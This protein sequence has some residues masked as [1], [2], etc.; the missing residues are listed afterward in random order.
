MPLFLFC[1]MALLS[2]FS[3]IILYNC[4]NWIW[5]I[6]RRL[7]EF[8]KNL[9]KK[10]LIQSVIYNAQ[11]CALKANRSISLFLSSDMDQDFLLATV[12][13][14][15]SAA[16]C[17]KWNLLEDCASLMIANEQ[18]KTLGHLYMSKVHK[19]NQNYREELQELLLAKDI[20]AKE[21]V[22]ILKDRLFLAFIRN[23]PNIDGAELILS[24]QQMSVLHSET[25][26]TFPE[27]YIDAYQLDPNNV[28]AACFLASKWNESIAVKKLIALLETVPDIKVLDKIMQINTKLNRTEIYERIKNAIVSNAMSPSDSYIL[29]RV[30]FAAGLRGEGIHY[31]KQVASAFHPL[32]SPRLRE[33]HESD[34]QISG[35]DVYECNNCHYR[36]M[37]RQAYCPQC[38]RINTFV[39]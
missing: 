31:A 23:T 22:P 20:I 18:L 36:V 25:G 5:N 26:K 17:A 27:K 39:W 30:A 4:W 11:A 14:A 2:V 32:I 34:A 1:E 24:P 38:A 12:C 8:R 28:D 13:N 6:P 16:T 35:K 19:H 9:R 3:V 10:N 33:V 7:S 29:A 37:L 21:F 15:L